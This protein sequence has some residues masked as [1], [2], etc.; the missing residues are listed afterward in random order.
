[1]KSKKYEEATKIKTEL[2]DLIEN[3]IDATANNMML[4]GRK[5]RKDKRFLESI[6]IFDSAS[7]LSEKIENPENKLQMIQDCVHGMML[8]NEVMIEDDPDM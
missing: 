3:N 6:L 2:T 1:M 7:T 8:T 4:F 5:L